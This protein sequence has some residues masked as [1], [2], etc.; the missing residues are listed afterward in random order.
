M[1]SP[2]KEN[3]FTPIANEILENIYSRKFTANQLTILLVVFRFTYGFQR[4]EH[5]FSLGFLSDATG[6]DRKSIKR[7]LDDLLAKNVL[8]VT[9]PATFNE[10]R[11]LSFN[12]NYETWDIPK[13]TKQQQGVKTGT[14]G[15]ND[16]TTVGKND[17]TT[18]GKNDHTTV[19]KNDHQ[20]RNNKEIYIT[21]TTTTNTP[22]PIAFFEENLC[23]LSP[24]QMHEL[25]IW[26]EKFNGQKE[27][28]NEAIRI[29]DDR[30]RRNYGF[31]KTLLQEWKDNGLKTLHDVRVY[32]SNKFK[33][34][35]RIS[36][37]SFETKRTDIPPKK[38]ID[39]S[40]GEDWN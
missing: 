26:E 17:H 20:E 39:F 25:I 4:K 35:K 10:P 15:K 13:R 33:N 18:V 6:I 36:N 2:Q 23:R 27:I 11:K 16:H 37:N 28:L 22:E 5:E 12:K 9:K 14:V 40:E 24:F 8:V 21:T 38:H 7:A 34:N 3:G 31:V 30:N 1:A 19:G 32:E 29:A